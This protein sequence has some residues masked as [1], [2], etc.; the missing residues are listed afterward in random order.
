MFAGSIDCLGSDYGTQ[1]KGAGRAADLKPINLLHCPL[2][3]RIFSN[4][5]P[6]YIIKFHT[7]LVKLSSL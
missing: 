7:I 3:H 4:T 1:V 5:G 6:I 2:H